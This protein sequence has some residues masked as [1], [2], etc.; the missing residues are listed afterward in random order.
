MICVAPEIWEAA[1]LLLALASELP[2]SMAATCMESS[3]STTTPHAAAAAA[4]AVHNKYWDRQTLAHMAATTTRTT[5]T[6]YTY[7]CMLWFLLV[8]S[9]FRISWCMY[10]AVDF[11]WFNMI[12]PCKHHLCY[13]K[14]RQRLQAHMATTTTTG[15]LAL[16]THTCVC[17]DSY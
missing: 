11:D 17:Y 3:H 6:A 12:C 16:L 7:M 2:G 9:F 5:S 15:L 10:F 4:A 1:R 8:M 14:D 13:E